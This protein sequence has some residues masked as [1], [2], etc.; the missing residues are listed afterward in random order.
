MRLQETLEVAH[1]Q[2]PQRHLRAQ[3]QGIRVQRLHFCLRLRV[4]CVLPVD[5]I[6]EIPVGALGNGCCWLPNC[7]APGKLEKAGGNRG[8]AGTRHRGAWGCA[9]LTV[10]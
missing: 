1:T 7:E 3:P 9:T 10:V 4:G 8:V 5:Q 2:L 6:G